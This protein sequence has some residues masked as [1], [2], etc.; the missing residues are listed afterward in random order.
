M[1]IADVTF[2]I[3]TFCNGLRVVAYVPQIVTLIRDRSGAAAISFGTWRLFLVSHLSAAA[4]AFENMNDLPLGLLF[5]SNSFG[6]L[7]ILLIAGW[8]R[9]QCGAG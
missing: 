8:K 6:C 1:A 2:L 7:A 4:Y 5:L 9:Q 3:F